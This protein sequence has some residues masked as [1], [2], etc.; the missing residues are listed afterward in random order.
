[1]TDKSMF[2]QVYKKSTPAPTTQKEKHTHYC[3]LVE[4]FDFEKFL[5]GG[6]PAIKEV[7]LGATKKLWKRVWRGFVAD[8][9]TSLRQDCK[10]HVAKNG[11]RT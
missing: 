9:A 1:M 5:I 8:T 11:A 6:Y 10:C 3:I 2:Y 4:K 7:M